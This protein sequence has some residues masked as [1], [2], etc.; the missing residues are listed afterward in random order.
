MRRTAI[1]LISALI[2]AAFGCELEPADTS[3]PPRAESRPTQTPEPAR[4]PAPIYK[5]TK[6]VEIA[7]RGFFRTPERPAAGIFPCAGVG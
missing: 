5:A 6:P 2:V 7:E 3:M 4:T 1:A